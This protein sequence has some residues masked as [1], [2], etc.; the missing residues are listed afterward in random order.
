MT[1]DFCYLLRVRYAEC[2]AQKVVFNSRYSDY[3]D[4]AAGEYMRAV[5]GDYNDILAKGIDN[6]VVSFAINWKA[7]AR[8][9]EVLAISVVPSRIGNSSFT[10]Q[11]DFYRHESNEL[12]ASA[13]I[14][15]V[16]VSASQHQKM[17]VPQTMR[18]QLECGAGGLVVDHAGVTKG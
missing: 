9:D 17:P 8:F 12:I 2:D 15:Y 4:L 1:N 5:W 11:V 10:F 3:V 18:E 7:S 16:M 6:Q 13:E 14:V